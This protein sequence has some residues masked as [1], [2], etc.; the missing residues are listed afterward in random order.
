MCIVSVKFIRSSVSDLFN[1]LCVWWNNVTFCR[2]DADN[3]KT[4]LLVVVLSI[5]FMSG[6]V[7]QDGRFP[8]LSIYMYMVN[9]ELLLL[10]VLL[11]WLSCKKINTD[12]F[13]FSSPMTISSFFHLFSVTFC[14]LD[15][16][17]LKLF[18][19]FCRK[20]SFYSHRSATT[21]LGK[22]YDLPFI[23][24]PH[25]TQRPLETKS[26]ITSK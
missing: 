8:P 10:P 13:S 6:N 9:S 17:V 20:G 5:I 1:P 16:L 3:A 26:W 18:F 22:A 21:M 7:V 15:V 11:M 4:G 12:A 2:N 14:D 23:A 24:S 25:D 19:V